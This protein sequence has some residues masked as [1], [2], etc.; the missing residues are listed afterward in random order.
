M[1]FILIY[2][3]TVCGFERDPHSPR[4]PVGD[5]PSWQSICWN[6]AAAFE[7][8][9]HL[10]SA[11]SPAEHQK[12]GVWLMLQPHPLDQRH[13][14]IVINMAETL[15]FLR[16]ARPWFLIIKYHSPEKSECNRPAIRGVQVVF[17]VE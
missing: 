7:L 6:L 2:P 13:N 16:C 9:F 14:Y 15:G 4:A 3:L 5:E 12:S 10:Q 17:W 1:N 11:V 8:Q